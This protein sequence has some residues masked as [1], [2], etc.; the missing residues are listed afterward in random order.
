[1]VQN[2]QVPSGPLRHLYPIRPIRPI[3]RKFRLEGGGF[4]PQ[5]RAML[6]NYPALVRAS[7]AAACA[8]FALLSL[9]EVP[10]R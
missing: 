5:H 7:V 9:H 8:G 1:L 10:R 6:L 4:F 3:G 2:S